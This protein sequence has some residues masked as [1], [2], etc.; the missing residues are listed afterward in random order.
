MESDF[1]IIIFIILI[2]I[3]LV[4]IYRDSQKHPEASINQSS[5]VS[6][7]Q[8]SDDQIDNFHYPIEMPNPADIPPPSA[9]VPFETPPDDR[10]VYFADRNVYLLPFDFLNFSLPFDRWMYYHYPEFYHSYYNVYWPFHSPSGSRRRYSPKSISHFTNFDSLEPDKNSTLVRGPGSR[11]AS[12]PRS[13]YEIN[14]A[15]YPTRESGFAGGLWS[16]QFINGGAYKSGLTSG[17]AMGGFGGGSNAYGA[18]MSTDT[19][20]RL[21][22][23]SGGKSGFYRGIEHFCPTNQSKSQSIKEPRNK[24]TVKSINNEKDKVI[25]RPIDQPG[26]TKEKVIIRPLI[27]PVEPPMIVDNPTKELTMSLQAQIIG[28]TPVGA[29]PVITL[30]GRLILENNVTAEK[31]TVPVHTYNY[32]PSNQYVNDSQADNGDKNIP[33]NA[34][35]PFNP[36]KT[37]LALLVPN[38]L[39]RFGNNNLHPEHFG[40]LNESITDVLAPIRAHDPDVSKYGPLCKSNVC[41]FNVFD[42][43]ETDC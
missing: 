1:S 22:G 29:N 42:V 27:T 8:V 32:R 39:N 10:Y 18:K 41:N 30:P 38:P 23:G 34:N 28:V 5:Q 43:L 25:I 3:I 9:Y 11:F 33:Q 37:N 21:Y 15:I 13:S 6:V 14:T 24:I 12:P 19:P 31:S 17:R 16:Q 20:M 7:N 26:K 2:V 35:S 40:C 4:M 36:T